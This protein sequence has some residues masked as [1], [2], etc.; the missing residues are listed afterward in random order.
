MSEQPTQHD[1]WVYEQQCALKVKAMIEHPGWT[2]VLEPQLKRHKQSL[3][4]ELLSANLTKAEEFIFVRQ[5][6]HACDS[7]FALIKSIISLGEKAAEMLQKEN[8]DIE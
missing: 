5:S 1:E 6:I 3:M 8:E 7:V 4:N 2:E